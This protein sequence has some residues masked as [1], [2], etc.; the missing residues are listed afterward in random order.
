M[1][2]HILIMY[3][4]KFQ[5]KTYKMYFPKIQFVFFLLFVCC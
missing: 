5:V 3:I 2:I 1:Y 4:C